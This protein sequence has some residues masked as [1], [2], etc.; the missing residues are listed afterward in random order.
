MW[1]TPPSHRCP[2][3][4]LSCSSFR[5]RLRE[6]PA[7]DPPRGASL[8]PPPNYSAEWP[9]QSLRFPPATR[10]TGCAASTPHTT[11]KNFQRAEFP[12]EADPCSR[13]ATGLR[14]TIHRLPDRSTSAPPWPFPRLIDVPPRSE[15]RVSRRDALLRLLPH[16]SGRSA[17]LKQN[18]RLDSRKAT[19]ACPP[20]GSGLRENVCPAV[21]R[22]SHKPGGPPLAM[23]ALRKAPV[24]SNPAALLASR[25]LVGPQ[26][27]QD[28]QMHCRRSQ[29]WPA[30]VRRK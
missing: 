11:A 24:P 12:A 14:G 18:A 2:K 1:P 10:M 22:R 26:T 7:R 20:K 6:R 16:R 21:G 5:Q 28:S 3:P 8:V 13:R 29:I 4:P 15:M 17:T 19:C 30:I 9:I 27:T 23:T 25:T